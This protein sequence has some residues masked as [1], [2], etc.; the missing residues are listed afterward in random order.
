MLQLQKEPKLR[1]II[2][3]LC[4][5]ALIIG[6]PAFIHAGSGFY[7]K[8]FLSFE[9]GTSMYRRFINRSIGI[10]QKSLPPGVDIVSKEKDV[11]FF[12]LPDDEISFYLDV[13]IH[14]QDSEQYSS[15]LNRLNQIGYQVIDGSKTVCYSYIPFD[16]TIEY[17][18]DDARYDTLYW[19]EAAIPDD[20]HNTIEYFC[21]EHLD[22]DG[23]IEAI[24]RILALR[25]G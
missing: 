8:H 15:E 20:A 23:Q 7:R 21:A 2:P 22:S 12:T 17:Y 3:L 1:T 11:R 6:I 9:L 5:F 4:A 18:F 10:V 16:K 13:V 19:I 24:N 25:R 14:F